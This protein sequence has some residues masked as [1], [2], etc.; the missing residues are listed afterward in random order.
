MLSRE[1]S[2]NPGLLPRCAMH[3]SKVSRSPCL[4]TYVQ[5]TPHACCIASALPLTS[6]CREDTGHGARVPPYTPERRDTRRGSCI[7]ARPT[8]YNTCYTRT[9]TPNPQWLRGHCHAVAS[10]KRRLWPSSFAIY[11]CHLR[12]ITAHL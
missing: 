7:D 3:Y 2:E 4:R 9:H 6:L 12:N 1:T 10:I 5:H 8:M 11:S